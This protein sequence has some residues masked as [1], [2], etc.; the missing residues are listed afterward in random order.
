MKYKSL[1]TYHSKDMANVKV[2]ESGYNF[3]VKVTT[4]IMVPLESFRH[5]K[6]AYEIPISY[7][8]KDIANVKSF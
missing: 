2:L 1:I 3:K 5:K 8:S 7:H 6:H 4:S